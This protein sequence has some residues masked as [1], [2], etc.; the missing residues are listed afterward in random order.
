MSQHDAESAGATGPDFGIE[1][2]MT[3]A[4]DRMSRTADGSD[5]VLLTIEVAVRNVGRDSVWPAMERA[6]FE[7]APYLDVPAAGD[8]LAPDA[9]PDAIGPTQQFSLASRAGMRLEAGT[10]TT[11]RAQYLAKPA[12]LYHVTFRLPSKFGDGWTWQVSRA[13]WVAEDRP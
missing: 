3:V 8:F 7:I 2:T 10:T 12:T 5:V 4:D 1:A 6:G 11:F 9:S 13:F